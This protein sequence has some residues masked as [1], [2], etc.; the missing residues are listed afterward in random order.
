VFLAGAGLLLLIGLVQHTLARR[1]LTFPDSSRWVLPQETLANESLYR[2]PFMG[3]GPKPSQAAALLWQQCRQTAPVCISLI[4][5]SLLLM[6][7][8]ATTRDR[9]ARSGGALMLISGGL[10][11]GFITLSASWL[12]VVTF[13]ADNRHRRYAFLTDRGISPTKV[14]W[15]RLAPTLS[16]ALFLMISLVAIGHLMIRD[17]VHGWSEVWQITS[18]II[19]MFAFGQLVSQWIERP[20]LAFLAAPAYTGVCILPISYFLEGSTLSWIGFTVPVLLFASWHLSKRWLEGRNKTAHTI[21]VV[22][23]TLLAIAL[24]C[25]MHA[26]SRFITLVNRHL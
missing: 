5:L 18:L 2:P 25:L 21:Q 4:G 11:P 13:Y 6:L 19:V 23:Y 8:Y 15:T 26:G 10:A 9:P 14:W 1:R 7:L 12:G 22:G 17:T 16:G 20:V 3:V 24:P